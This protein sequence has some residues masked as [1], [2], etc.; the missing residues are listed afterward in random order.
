MKNKEIMCE[1]QEKCYLFVN[2]S[3]LK[4]YKDSREYDHKLYG[5]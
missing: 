5:T 2:L 1:Q 4:A 3:E